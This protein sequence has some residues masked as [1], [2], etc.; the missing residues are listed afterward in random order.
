MKGRLRVL[1]FYQIITVAK[2]SHA[3]M[4]QE[5]VPVL[6]FFRKESSYV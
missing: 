2:N 6:Y 5:S 3:I 4:E 1:S